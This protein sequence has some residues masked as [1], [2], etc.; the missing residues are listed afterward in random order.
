MT[1][2]VSPLSRR[3]TV[4]LALLLAVQTSTHAADKQ[5]KAKETEAKRLMGL[6]KNAEKQGRLLEA[7]Q[8]YLAS[9][10]VWFNEDAEKALEHVAE[11]ADKEVKKLMNDAAQ[12][13]AAENFTRAGQLLET[14]SGLH[15]GNLAIG[16]NLALTKFQQGNRDE[17]LTLLEQ[18]VGALR[19][20][21]PRRRLAELYTALGTGDRLTVVA[22]VARQQVARLNDAILQDSDR[23]PADDDDVPSVTEGGLCAQMQKLQDGLLKNPA[24]LFN[25]AKCAE[26]DGRLADAIRLLNEY[27]QAAPMAADSDE[28]KAR[29]VVL[30][31]LAALPAPNGPQ[32]RTLYAS[33]GKHVEAR[34]YDQ[35]I[36]DYQKADEAAPVF[37]ESKR[38]IAILLEAEG[39]IDRARTYW[40]QVL[41]AETTD[42]GRRDTQTVVDGLDAEKAQYDELIGAARL[43]LRDLVG[44]SFLEGQPVGRIYAAYQLRLANEKIQSAA[45]L[46]PLAAEA[47]LLQALVCSQ[48]ND[49]RCVRASF[50]AQRSLT[51][52]VSFYGAV[53]YKGV[54]PKDST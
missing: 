11:F 49:F 54:E 51:L 19:E 3:V 6:G 15:P 35:A 37:T 1:N 7:R 39:Q 2:T 40:R 24:L 26:T 23:E 52:P 22:P 16:C 29:I 34:A 21:E 17:S 30:K 50:D 41:G 38:R 36:A 43:L 53:F 25:L 10:R 28:V 48:M 45:Y 31:D 13:Y 44:R 5:Q 9:E 18:C 4:L 33:A 14:A 27:G 47:N 20:R 12:A 46:L 42:E 8:Q 32:V